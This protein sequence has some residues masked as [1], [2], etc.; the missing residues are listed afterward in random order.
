MEEM[1]QDEHPQI[2]GE[3]HSDRLLQTKA[4]GG[5]GD[6]S[7]G[8]G[9]EVGNEGWRG[10]WKLVMRKEIYP[11]VCPFELGGRTQA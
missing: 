5:P 7:V 3:G 10:L 11:Q 6:G 9:M 2:S 4:P 8:V 1:S